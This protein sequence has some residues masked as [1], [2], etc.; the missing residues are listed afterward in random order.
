MTGKKPAVTRRRY[1]SSV[2]TE[3]RKR[4]VDTAHRLL[5]EGGVGALTIRRLAI[6]ADV[7]PR[8]L[9]RLFGDKDG[10]I[11]A[12]V[13]DRMTEV[14]E[15]IRKSDRVYTLETVF[16]ELDWMVSEMERD[17]LYARVVVDF[18]FAAEQRE[19]EVRELTSVAHGRFMKWLAHQR[20][21]GGVRSELNFEMIARSHVMHEFLVYRRWASGQ[22]DSARCRLELR[23]CFL[24]SASILLTDDLQESYVKKLAKIQR[25]LKKM[26]AAAA[27]ST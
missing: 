1:T 5:G 27:S 4:I 20:A 24:Q 22:C 26:D 16:K 18:V 14:R 15:H 13:T 12:T 17:T 11:S 10:V 25:E 6:E 23:A 7:A 8:T 19:R 21:A 9:Y 2:M 3:R